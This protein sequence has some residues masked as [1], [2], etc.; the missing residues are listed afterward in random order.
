MAE[1]DARS[2]PAGV[3]RLEPGD[4]RLGLRFLRRSLGAQDQ[5][6]FR[7]QIAQARE[8]VCDEAQ[9]LFTLEGIVSSIRLVT[10]HLIEQLRGVASQRPFQF[11]SAFSRHCKIP[12]RGQSC[13]H[14]AHV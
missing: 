8:T 4:E 2:A 13:M 1:N 9:A 3:A 11:M 6:A 7:I 10:V 5:A 12:L 14:H